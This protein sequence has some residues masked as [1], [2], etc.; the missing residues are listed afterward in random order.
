MATARG[1]TVVGG[2]VLL[3]GGGT[4]IGLGAGV[5]AGP[6]CRAEQ[7]GAINPAVTSMMPKAARPRRAVVTSSHC[8]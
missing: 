6:V 3:V 1:A 5:A 2:A 4:G 7:A 8:R